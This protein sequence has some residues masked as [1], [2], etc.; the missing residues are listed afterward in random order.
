MN[1]EILLLPT[2]DRRFDTKVKC[3]TERASFWV[4]F[5]TVRSLTRVKCRGIARGGMGGFGID[6]YIRAALVGRK[7]KGEFLREDPDQ[8]FWS[9]AFLWSKSFFRSVI[10]RIHSGQGFIGSLIWVICKRIIRS[11]IWRVPLGE[12]SEVNHSAQRFWPWERYRGYYTVARRYEFYVRVARTIAHEWAHRTS[13]IL[14]LPREHKIHIFS[15]PCNVIFIIWR[16]QINKSK[17]RESWRHWT[18]RHSQR[19]H[20]EN[21]PLGS[22]MKW[23]MESTSGLVPSKTLSSI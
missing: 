3:P 1:C 12:G 9:V 11:M 14:F 18:I 15:P 2:A 19:W 23:R 17:R 16:N 5:P 21:T 13:E 7:I 20:T 4:K 10:Y 6:W 22:R 8:D